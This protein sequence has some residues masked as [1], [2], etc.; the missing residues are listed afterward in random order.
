MPGFKN[1]I[2]C[3]FTKKI[4]ENSGCLYYHDVLIFKAQGS[5]RDN[6]ENHCWEETPQNKAINYSGKQFIFFS[7]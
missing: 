6:L 2:G 5:T 1:G 4:D 7:K 3:A